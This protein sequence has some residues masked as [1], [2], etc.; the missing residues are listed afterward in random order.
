ML[1]IYEI[2]GAFDNYVLCECCAGLVAEDNDRGVMKIDTADGD[3]QC[4]RC[5]LGEIVTEQYPY[6]PTEADDFLMLVC[7]ETQRRTNN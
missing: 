4:E 3:A 1:G 5:G 2:D 6:D 7:E